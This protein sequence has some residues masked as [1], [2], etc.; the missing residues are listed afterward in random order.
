MFLNL[1]LVTPESDLSQF[2]YEMFVTCI[3]LG[4]YTSV[5]SYKSIGE[6]EGKSCKLFQLLNHE[7]SRRFEVFLNNDNT[8]GKDTG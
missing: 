4:K 2:S 6:R 1:V 3:P 7:A 5:R 8:T